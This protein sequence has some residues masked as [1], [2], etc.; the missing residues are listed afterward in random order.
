M[1]SQTMNLKREGHTPSDEADQSLSWPS[2]KK[3]KRR[4]RW[5]NDEADKTFIPGMPTT[6]PADAT[7]EQKEQYLLQLQIE[8]SSRRLRS[9]DLGISANPEERLAK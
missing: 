6:L 9:G 3:K 8:E 7:D 5:A 1:S 4:S 2:E